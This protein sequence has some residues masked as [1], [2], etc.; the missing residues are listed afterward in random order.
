MVHSNL[1]LKIELVV[2]TTLILVLFLLGVMKK[3]MILSDTAINRLKKNW[4]RFRIA[5]FS[6][7]LVMILFLALLTIETI[8]VE[9]GVPFRSLYPHVSSWLKVGMVFFLVLANII[10]LQIVKH[11]TEGI[12]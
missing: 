10:N 5:F 2:S 4:L 1:I 3:D 9:T 11:L 6:G 12:E 7:F 8:E